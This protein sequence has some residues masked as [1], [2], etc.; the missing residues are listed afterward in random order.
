MTPPSV[1]RTGQPHWYQAR[2]YLEVP[3][4]SRGGHGTERLRLRFSALTTV[5]Y[6]NQLETPQA[7]EGKR[8]VRCTRGPSQLPDSSVCD[9]RLSVLSEHQP[10]GQMQGRRLAPRKLAQESA[11]QPQALFLFPDS[12]CPQSGAD[13]RPHDY[14]L[15]RV[16]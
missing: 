5:P 11:R 14:R 15:T 3:A 16:W 6:L 12:W 8:E 1:A 10:A 9:S 2:N 7:A 4:I 13:F